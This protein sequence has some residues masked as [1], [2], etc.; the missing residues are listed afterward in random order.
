MDIEALK[1]VPFLLALFGGVATH[2]LKKVMELHQQDEKFH[3]RD[4][5]LAYPYQTAVTLLMSLGGYLG[6]AATAELSLS[7]AFLMGVTANSF[8]G[9]APGKRP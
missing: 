3:L 8:A 9:A 4:Y 5:L 1:H 2:I 7:S 6:L